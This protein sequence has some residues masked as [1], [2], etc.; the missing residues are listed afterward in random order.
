MYYRIAI[1]LCMLALLLVLTYKLSC[2]CLASI[3][4]AGISEWIWPHLCNDGNNKQPI[5]FALRVHIQSLFI[6]YELFLII[7]IYKF[8]E[9]QKSSSCF[10]RES[11]IEYVFIPLNTPP[12]AVTNYPL[13]QTFVT[14][15]VQ[16]TEN[17]KSKFF[18]CRRLTLPISNP[19]VLVH[20]Q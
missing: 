19:F 3:D 20:V 13:E 6:R 4:V 2:W 5:L 8:H 11:E 16:M 10:L 7:F 15:H 17:R 18:I 12:W 1:T 14:V 9:A